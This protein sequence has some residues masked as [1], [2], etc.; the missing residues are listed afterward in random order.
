MLCSWREA[1][2]AAFVSDDLVVWDEK[3]AYAGAAD[4]LL[5]CGPTGLVLVDFK[6]SN[7]LWPS[8]GLQVRRTEQ[9]STAA[10]VAACTSGWGGD[11]CSMCLCVRVR[12]CVCVRACMCAAAWLVGW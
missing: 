12:V 9:A 3:Y 2:T 4:A 5:Q 7:A 6:T 10:Q 11:I 8:Y 1:R